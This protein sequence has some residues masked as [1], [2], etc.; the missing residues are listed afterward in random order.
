MTPEGQN[1]PATLWQGSL[2]DPAYEHDACG[3][4]FVAHIKGKRS[5]DILRMGLRLLEN[6]V[7]RGACGC[8]PET[9]DGAGILIQVPDAF[10]RAQVSFPLPPKGEYGIGMVFLPRGDDHRRQCERAIEQATRREG[11]TFLGWRSVPTDSR[12]IGAQA[13][14]TEPLIRQ[15]FIARGRTTAPGDFERKLYVLRKVIESAIAGATGVPNPK[16]FYIA[17][18]SSRTLIYKGLLLPHQMPGYYQDLVDEAMVSAIALVHQRFSTNT[19]PSWPLAHPYRYIAHNGEINTINGNRNWMR[20]RE[21]GLTSSILGDDIKKLIPFVNRDGSDS[22]SLDNAVEL[23]VQGGKSLAQ[24]MMILI[25]E[26]WS[27]NALMEPAR[28][29]FYEYHACLMEPWDGPAAVAFTDGVQVGAVLDRNGLRPARY[30]VTHDDL[31]VLASETGVIPF[32]IE[33]IKERGRLQ[34]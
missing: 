11:Q 13:R 14:E 27:G 16:D 32:E 20:A 24:A 3:V 10:L 2:Y 28:R 30:T 8:D 29:A 22:A 23:L 34:P 6:L 9:G 1:D 15:C 19:F 17:S 18:L 5:H 4:G 12:A 26:A 25:P 7:H 31:V 21:A 33:R